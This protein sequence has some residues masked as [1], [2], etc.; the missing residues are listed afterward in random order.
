MASTPTG[1]WMIFVSLRVHLAVILQFIQVNSHFHSDSC[2]ALTRTTVVNSAA[3]IRSLIRLR[4]L[5]VIA[6]SSP[7]VHVKTV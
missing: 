5:V 4:T 3:A 6:T 7:M 2:T 1:M